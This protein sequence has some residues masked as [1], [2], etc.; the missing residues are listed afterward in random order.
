MAAQV[1]KAAFTRADMIELLGAQLPVDAPG[2]PRTLIEAMA[3]E[4]GI[5]ISAPRES[6]HREGHE[7]FTVE[8]VIA[9]EEQILDMADESDNR[10]RLDLRPEDIGDL[11]A[12]HAR[13][14]AAIATSAQLVQPLQA[15]AGAGKTHSLKAL[16]AAAHRAR[17]QVLV[18]AP[19]GKAVDEALTEGAGD[20]GL[21]VAKVLRQIED[22]Q[23]LI[24][25]S[26]VLVV[27]E[28]AMVGTPDLRKLLAC[29]V[30]GRAKIVLVGDAYQL[31]PVKAR[32]GMFEQLCAELPWSQRLSAVWQMHDPDE[33]D[34][35]LA[36]RSAHGNRL[37]NAVHWY[38]TQG[39]LHTGD[40]IAMASDALAAYQTARTAGK[41]ALL[42]CD[43]WE[44]AD[45]LNKRIHDARATA[46]QPTARPTVHA[47]RG[48]EVSVGDLIMSRTND[49]TIALR[50]TP[51]TI[52]Q[53]DQVRNGNRWRV[54]AVDPDRNRLAAERLGD[55]A[56][57]VFDGDYLREHVTLGCAATVHAAQ[58]VTADASYGILGEHASRAMAYVATTRGR[59]TNEAFIYQHI[60]GEAD[61][62]HSPPVTEPEMYTLRRGNSYSAAHHFRQILVH[63]DRPQTM[64]DHAAHTP[65]QHLPTEIA[66]LL[67][68][69]EVRRIRRGALWREQAARVRRYRDG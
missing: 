36:L 63:D 26:T 43:T 34:A 20:T 25:R 50:P 61:H 39:R 44:M 1:D 10:S 69:N 18:C 19:T 33:R 35:S 42:V 49:A 58:G 47:A 22:H 40:P 38:R 57:A 48:Q 54:A 13:A 3:D 9:E 7:R 8:A 66:E 52:D 46:A 31:S 53:P 41:D 2:D 65:T 16:R 67:G 45:A 4:V 12:D 17:K 5:R 68:R 23:L 55:G 24:D 60:T 14:I 37:R 32:G 29:G 64:H 11:S 56:R 59:D 21:T 28:A 15:P 27:D 6:H 51:G 30:A 62:Q